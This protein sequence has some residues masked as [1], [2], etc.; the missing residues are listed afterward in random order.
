MSTAHF[1][2]VALILRHFATGTVTVRYSRCDRD[3]DA[4]ER[5]GYFREQ[6]MAEFG[7][8]WSLLAIVD[9]ADHSHP[10]VITEEGPQPT[11]AHMS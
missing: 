2:H 6:V 3:L 7:L 10:V 1:D 5:W 8:L 11:D 4:K 9:D